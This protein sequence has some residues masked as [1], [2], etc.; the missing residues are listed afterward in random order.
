[1]RRV[2]ILTSETPNN[3]HAGSMQLLRAFQGYPAENLMVVGPKPPA[4]ARLLDC[5][6]VE[7]P[8]PVQKLRNTRCHRFAMS[9]PILCKAFRPSPRKISTML[10]TFIP[11]VVFTV[12]DNFSWYQTAWDF[13]RMAGK[14]LITMTMDEPDCFEKNLVVLEGKKQKMIREIYQMA[15]TNLCVSKQMSAHLAEKYQAK[16][17][18]FYFGPPDGIFPRAAQESRHLRQK[19]RLTLGYAG[20]LT[21]GYGEA[22][23]KIIQKTEDIGAKV[24][25]YS[26]N[27]P[28][29]DLALKAEYAGSFP[30]EI[31]WKKFQT[32]C[33]ASLLVYPFQHSQS[34]LYRTH[35][36]TKLSEYVWQGMPVVMVGPPYA[37]GIIW[38][39]ENPDICLVE[40]S[41]E[42]A[43]LNKALVHL[44]GLPQKRV[45][46]AL[47]GNKKAEKEFDPRQKRRIFHQYLK[48]NQAEET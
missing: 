25:I 19:G 33:D 20:G 48:N 12:M 27:K 6:N 17:K 9:L 44:A 11:D 31:L 3:L 35:F 32:E 39:L 14:P 10:K 37:T 5:P 38:G 21:Y 23:L 7:L 4:G 41:E 26:R 36:P 16:T 43:T 18:T 8:F 46:M 24:R 28:E 13:C 40:T 34:F 47:A 22:L 42:M 30:H 29:G 45:S 2:L 15:E 1:M